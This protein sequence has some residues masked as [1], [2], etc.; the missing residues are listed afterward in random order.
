M[1]FVGLPLARLI[2]LDTFTTFIPL[3]LNCPSF[4]S[5]S[6]M[7]WCTLTIT[8]LGLDLDFGSAFLVFTLALGSTCCRFVFDMKLSLK[9]LFSGWI[10]KSKEF[11]NS[12]IRCIFSCGNFVFIACANCTWFGLG[13][14][15][16]TIGLTG[17]DIE[18]L[19][20]WFRNR[21]RLFWTWIKFCSAWEVSSAVALASDRRALSWLILARA[22]LRAIAQ[23]NNQDKDLK[24][25]L[26]R[27]Q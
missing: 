26:K 11:V 8:E 23:Q 21:L 18:F 12:R 10:K 3:L 13:L 24:Q 9:A 16:S 14:I 20:F 7:L 4:I 27:K 15:V 17:S 19:S 5:I 1:S 6:W 25:L 22:P 2:I